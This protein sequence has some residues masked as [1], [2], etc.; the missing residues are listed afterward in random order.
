LA[1]RAAMDIARVKF[2]GFDHSKLNASALMPFAHVAEIDAIFTDQ[3][4][5][6]GLTQLIEDNDVEL[7]IA[8]MTGR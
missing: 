7:H 5:A 1:S 2:A 6:P 4:L 3:V 8:G